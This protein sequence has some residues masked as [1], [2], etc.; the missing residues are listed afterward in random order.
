M[1]DRWGQTEFHRGAAS[2]RSYQHDAGHMPLPPG[3]G[4]DALDPLRSS[5]RGRRGS[6]RSMPSIQCG[7]HL[8]CRRRPGNVGDEVLA[9]AG[10]SLLPRQGV[11]NRGDRVEA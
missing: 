11:F 1:R 6:P 5:V 10:K 8:S 2:A 7:A 4:R 9:D 3:R